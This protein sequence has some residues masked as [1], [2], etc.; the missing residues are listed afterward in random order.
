MSR[1]TPTALGRHLVRFFEEYL[2]VQRGLSPHTIR[3]YRDA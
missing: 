3:S 1:M 2:P